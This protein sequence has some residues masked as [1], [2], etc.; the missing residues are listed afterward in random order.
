MP[1]RN[2]FE[3]TDADSSMRPVNSIAA[4]VARKSAVPPLPDPENLRKKAAKATSEKLR[5]KYLA[6]ADEL[7]AA[8]AKAQEKQARR[9]TGPAARAKAQRALE[10]AKWERENR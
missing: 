9:L 5:D 2:I 10:R 4:K 3:A 8:A 6:R 1:K 7:E